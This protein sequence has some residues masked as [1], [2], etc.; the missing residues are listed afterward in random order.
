LPAGIE[1]TAELL[2]DAVTMDGFVGLFPL[3]GKV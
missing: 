3:G 2:T 1:Q